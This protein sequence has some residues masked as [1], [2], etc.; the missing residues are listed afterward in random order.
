[1]DLDWLI[2]QIKIALKQWAEM[3]KEF[4]DLES[5]FNDLKE[6]VNNYFNN[7]DVQEEI[8]NK[9]DSMSETGQLSE[10]IANII[11]N[12]A[13]PIFV[14]SI[15][16][17]TDHSRI[18]VLTTDGNVYVWNGNTWYN[19]GLN[20]TQNFQQYLLVSGSLS[21]NTDAD[22]IDV[23]SVWNINGGYNYEN[24]PITSGLLQCFK[25]G[26]IIYQIAI[27]GDRNKQQQTFFRSKLST[28]WKDWKEYDMHPNA[29][30]VENTLDIN[31]DLNNVIETG[32]YNLS[33]GNNY[34]NSPVSTG[35]LTVFKYSNNL[36]YQN[37]VSYDT[38]TKGN[39]YNRRLLNTWNNWVA[40]ES[41]TISYSNKY[42]PMLGGVT[43]KKNKIEIT[44]FES[45][46]YDNSSGSLIDSDTYLR[47]ISL[48]K[49]KEYNGFYLDDTSIPN[50]VYMLFFDSDMNY[51]SY[52][53]ISNGDRLPVVSPKNSVYAGI[54]YNLSGGEAPEKLVINVV[55][56]SDLLSI[57]GT[58]TNNDKYYGVMNRVINN[59]GTLSNV[60]DEYKTVFIPN[61]KCNKIFDAYN[62]VN[63]CYCIDEAGQNVTPTEYV[64][65]TPTGRMYT[66]P[67][68]TVLIGINW[69]SNDESC[70]VAL[71]YTTNEIENKYIISKKIPISYIS[72]SEICAIGDSITYID[73]R[74]YGGKARLM[75]WQAYL[76][77]LGAFVQNYGYSGYAYASSS[78]S[79]GIANAIV[80]NQID[81]SSYNI[82][83]LFGGSNDV[84][85][86]TTIGDDNTD[87]TDPNIDSTTF[88][89]AIGKL[90]QYL[91]TENPN[92]I[93]FI[94][95]ILPSES[96]DRP[97]TKTVSYNEAIKKCADFWQLEC[98]DIFKKINVHPELNF[99]TYFYD[100]VH[101]NAL[102]CERI[103]K[104][105]AK[106][107]SEYMLI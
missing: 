106:H 19:T 105:I 79:A 103:G 32:V 5:A 67:S 97:Y 65:V 44:A 90:V 3:Q 12:I 36:V 62:A 58:P 39:I 55:D 52:I 57:T 4:T 74:A 46:Y 87:Y 18:Y 28:G 43:I 40:I 72:N 16:D 59:N 26:N 101:P 8:N 61:P 85:L 13:S 73:G 22:D 17:M 99:D 11:L 15:D 100:N 66:I 54:N 56:G 9:L 94:C 20:Y 86:N 53:N 29:I 6:Y 30:N 70:Y 93:I 37:V 64:Q 24:L 88:I 35:I 27:N 95:T 45:G 76:R 50:T 81:M 42:N 49:I 38:H 102:G 1:M 48:F 77:T 98:I 78:E 23:N 84:R 2:N 47:T 33:Q 83:V 51:L 14:E 10:D 69:K 7:L 25:T 80:D 41:S 91:R 34:L 89:G 60:T 75:G 104:I 92:M 107:V 21:N 71:I 63:N 68:G 31:T 82:A 96:S